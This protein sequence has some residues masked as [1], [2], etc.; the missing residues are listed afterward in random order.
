M[1]CTKMGQWPI[2]SLLSK[3]L[4]AIITRLKMYPNTMIIAIDLLN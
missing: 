3:P 4:N 1:H 2:K